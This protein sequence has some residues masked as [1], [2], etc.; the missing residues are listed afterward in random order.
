MKLNQYFLVLGV[1]LA[2]IGLNGC[3]KDV[4][5]RT[6]SFTRVVPIYEK[7]EAIRGKGILFGLPRPIQSPGRVEGIGTQLFINEQGQGIHVFDNTDP[8]NPISAGFLEIPGNYNFMVNNGF[9]YANSY[10]DLLIFE[11]APLTPGTMPDQISYMPTNRLS[12]VFNAF[13][14]KEQT[15]E[16]AF[17][18]KTEP[19]TMV[20]DCASDAEFLSNNEGQLVAVV[21]KDFFN[22]NEFALANS[23]D[24]ATIADGYTRF[25][26]DAS[27][28]QFTILEGKLYGLDNET[29]NII[30]L[31]NPAQP[32][33]LSSQLFLLEAMKL[34]NFK[35]SLAATN[36][37][38]TTIFDV[39]N[40]IMVAG[41]N[42]LSQVTPCDY[43]AYKDD[44]VFY[45]KNT[46]N[47]CYTERTELVVTGL[48]TNNPAFIT[49]IYPMED[50]H[51]LAVQDGYLY[52]CDGVNGL[53]IYD[54]SNEEL[55]SDKLVANAKDMNALE[56]MPLESPSDLLIVKGADGIYQ[57]QFE[58]HADGDP[59]LLSKI[60]FE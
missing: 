9:L 28:A 39:S 46:D 48:T 12:N 54:I 19:I 60:G 25:L 35:N 5:T 30:D 23:L 33:F 50:P 31:Q 20:L 53:K 55:L 24:S 21:D 57:Y 18:Y 32:E 34:S 3:L 52:L 44:L 41:S 1:V 4:C 2:S 51:G 38:G 13:W 45:S 15:G 37:F 49:G 56:V 7:M 17:S 14:E 29:L 42:P 43:F 40:G 8:S 27:I 36:P 6:V 16:I 11:L 59:L 10:V 58:S 22:G 26:T 47:Q